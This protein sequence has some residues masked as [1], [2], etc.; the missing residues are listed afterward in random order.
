[1]KIYR[2]GIHE[3]KI[4]VIEKQPKINVYPKK[5]ELIKIKCKID[6]CNN[7]QWEDTKKKIQS[8]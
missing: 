5:D 7:K 1:M 3:K 6:K 2:L 4:N 8:I